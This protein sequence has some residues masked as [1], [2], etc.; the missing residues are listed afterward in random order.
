MFGMGEGVSMGYIPR[1]EEGG[2][3][4]HNS[5]GVSVLT[6]GTDPFPIPP[7][8]FSRKASQNPL[9]TSPS[10]APLLPHI[11]RNT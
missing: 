6:L 9:E 11:D 2:D 8:D 5:Y 10:L 3:G 1:E 7:L 4:N